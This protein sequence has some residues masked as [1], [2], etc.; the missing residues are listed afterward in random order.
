[1]ILF[2]ILAVSLSILLNLV[3]MDG[4]NY[5]RPC[6]EYMFDTLGLGKWWDKIYDLVMKVYTKV[7][8]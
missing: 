6:T 4:F 3:F 1:L 8:A 5:F 7:F 2:V